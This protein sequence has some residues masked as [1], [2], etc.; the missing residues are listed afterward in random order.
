MNEEL[1]TIKEVAEHFH[2]STK[3]IQNWIKAGKM[4]GSRPGRKW[5]FSEEQV[6]KVTQASEPLSSE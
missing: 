6:R 4:K 1:Y 2:V 5:L 3:T